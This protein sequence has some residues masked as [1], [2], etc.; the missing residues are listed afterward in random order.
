MRGYTIN[1]YLNF[2]LGYKLTINYILVDYNDKQ[3]NKTNQH[4]LN[5]DLI[6]KEQDMVYKYCYC[7][8]NIHMKL[9]QLEWFDSELKWGRYEF[10]KVLCI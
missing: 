7:L 8:L 3:I 4:R 1:N 9:T 10:P 6:I 5:K 2:N